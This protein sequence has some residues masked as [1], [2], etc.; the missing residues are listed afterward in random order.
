[1][2]GIAVPEGTSNPALERLKSMSTQWAVAAAVYTG[3]KQL[4]TRLKNELTYTVSIPE[5]DDVFDEV[6]AWLLERIPE[7]RRRSLT[8]RTAR[9]RNG[10]LISPDEFLGSRPKTARLRLFHDGSRTQPV[11]IDG[12]RVKVRVENGNVGEKD[13]Y[14]QILQPGKVIFEARDAAGRDAVLGFI[15]TIAEARLAE[16]TGA[17]LYVASPWGSWRRR[18]DIPP[19]DLDTVVLAKGQKEALVEDL[20]R[21]F[22]TEGDYV[23]L[24]LPWHRGYVLEG[25]PGTGKTSVARALASHFGLDVYSLSLSDLNSDASLIDM[26]GGVE[27]RSMLLLEDVDIAHAAASREEG[28]GATLSGLLNAL[29]GVGTPWGQV[30]VMTTNRVETLDKA[31]LRPGRADKVEHVGYLG[32]EQLG[33][34][35][36]MAFG[37]TPDL[38]PIEGQIAPVTVVEAIR[39]HLHDLPAAVAA[40]SQVITRG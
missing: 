38:P 14:K 27:P 28:K 32:D 25:P 31:L 9:K 24:G 17:R 1:M 22:A 35:F 7:H 2:N 30:V 12:H 36:A 10:E 19:R 40:V 3:G 18:N 21:F 37:E 29:D 4:Y 6:A 5:D 15:R 39:L 26:I 16:E 8:A 23:K 13:G 33:R 34:L 20:E 11:N